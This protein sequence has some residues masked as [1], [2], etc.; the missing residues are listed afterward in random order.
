MEGLSYWVYSNLK[1]SLG[2]KIFLCLYVEHVL[3]QV[4]TSKF[5]KTVCKTWLA[6]CYTKYNMEFFCI[7]T[8]GCK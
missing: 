6:T 8:S 4:Y 2:L 3:L 5:S 1:Y 7:N